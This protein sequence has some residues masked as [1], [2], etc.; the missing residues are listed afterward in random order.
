MVHN[1]IVLNSFPV[2]RRKNKN[3]R[4]RVLNEKKNY[5]NKITNKNEHNYTENCIFDTSIELRKAVKKEL[6]TR[7]ELNR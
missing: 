4:H 5:S 3:Y 6:C 2:F 1:T 7:S